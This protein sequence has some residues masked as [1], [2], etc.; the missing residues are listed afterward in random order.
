MNYLKIN[1]DVY[2]AGGVYDVV[3]VF[4]VCDGDDD[5][6]AYGANYANVF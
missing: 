1:D 4:Y 6:G 3:W 5:G 2:D